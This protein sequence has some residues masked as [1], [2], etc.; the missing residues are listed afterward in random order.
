MIC[1]KACSIHSLRDRSPRTHC[2]HVQ[3]QS[4][5]RAAARTHLQWSVG[6]SF[7]GHFGAASCFG[8]VLLRRA[9]PGSM[10]AFGRGGFYATINSYVVPL[11]SHRYTK[12]AAMRY[13]QAQPFISA[14]IC[15]CA[16]KNRASRGVES[17]CLE[18][19]KCSCCFLHHHFV[20]NEG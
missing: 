3:N 5:P 14:F 1:Q 20:P 17:F 6:L 13:A 11:A 15:G 7:G 18:V 8:K 2:H 19:S 9:A 16:R 12:V 4:S 10:Q